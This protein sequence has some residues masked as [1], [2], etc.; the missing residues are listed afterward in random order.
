MNY[1]KLDQH[2]SD[3]TKKVIEIFNL[4]DDRVDS[5]KLKLEIGV[6]DPTDNP[7]K[8]VILRINDGTVGDQIIQIVFE[9]EHFDRTILPLIKSNLRK[10]DIAFSEGIPRSL[11]PKPGMRPKRNKK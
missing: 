1:R 5:T 9:R 4:N 11:P 10:Q 7:R 6:T 3:R 8:L 2:I